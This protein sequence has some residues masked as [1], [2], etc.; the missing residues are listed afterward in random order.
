VYINEIHIP[1][2]IRPLVSSSKW[3]LGAMLAQS[4]QCISYRLH[5]RGIAVSFL[6]GARYF[7]SNSEKPEQ[8]WGPL[9]FLRSWYQRLLLW[10]QRGPSVKLTTNLRM[11]GVMP[12]LCHMPSRRSKGQILCIILEVSTT[13]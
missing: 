8:C 12:P 3:M 1:N 11:C 13:Y 4:V 9:Y 7:S 2:S 5:H 10:Q 6:A